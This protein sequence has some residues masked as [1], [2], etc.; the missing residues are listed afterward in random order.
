MY[1]SSSL[2]ASVS[3]CPLSIPEHGRSSVRVEQS[4]VIPNTGQAHEVSTQGVQVHVQLEQEL[5]H[6]LQLI[7]F[8]VLRL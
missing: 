6:L 4:V 8:L 1:A 5:L 3:V 7:L 2:K